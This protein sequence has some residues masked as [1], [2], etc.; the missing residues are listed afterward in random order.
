MNDQDLKTNYMCIYW[1]TMLQHTSF[2]SE[3]VFVAIHIAGP[4]VVNP[5][6]LHSLWQENWIDSPDSI[7][8]LTLTCL[9]LNCDQDPDWQQFQLIPNTLLQVL[10]NLSVGRRGAHFKWSLY[11]L[12]GRPHLSRGFTQAF[13][14]RILKRI[15]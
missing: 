14:Y 5:D 8:G 10:L 4:Q 3:R 7:I 11:S 13:Q 12:R 15:L 2:Q 1:Q 6:W 9:D